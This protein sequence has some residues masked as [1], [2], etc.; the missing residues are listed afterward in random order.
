MATIRLRNGTTVTVPDEVAESYTSRGRVD[1][2][3]PVPAE[4]RHGLDTMTV[5]QLNEY[6]EQNGIELAAARL[7]ADIIAAIER[8]TES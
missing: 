5:K 8:T 2:A 3:A 1:H 7:K 4:Q 6:A